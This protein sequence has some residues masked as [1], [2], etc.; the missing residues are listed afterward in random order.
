[1][2]NHPWVVVSFKFVKEDMNY[3]VIIEKSNKTVYGIS[4]NRVKTIRLPYR[5]YIGELLTCSKLN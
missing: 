5:P 4:S 2:S 1:M 3:K